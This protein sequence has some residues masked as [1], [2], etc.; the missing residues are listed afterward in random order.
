VSS[1]TFLA[2]EFLD[3]EVMLVSLVAIGVMAIAAGRR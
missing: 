1:P 3:S 2:G